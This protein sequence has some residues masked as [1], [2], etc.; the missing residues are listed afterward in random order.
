MIE[1]G[2]D[3]NL[4]Y[5]RKPIGLTALEKL[6]GKKRLTELIGAYITKPMGKPTLAPATDKR[7]AF[8]KKK[9]EEMFS[10]AQN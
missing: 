5:E 6:C 8:S 10:G 1:A 7:K 9:L 2:Y 4:L 3:A